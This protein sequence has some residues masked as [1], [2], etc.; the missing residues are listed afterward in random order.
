MTV[1]MP[2]RPHRGWTFDE[3]P[4]GKRWSTSR[5]TVTET[6][7]MVYATQF[8]FVEGLFLDATGSERAGYS[9]R[10]GIYEM[11]EVG[12]VLRDRIAGSPTVTEFRNLCCEQGMRTLRQDALSKMTDGQTTLQEVLRVTDGH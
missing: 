3:V 7:L 12:D 11:L 1:E 2:P 8:G 5:R 10:L 9:G 4:V 6:D